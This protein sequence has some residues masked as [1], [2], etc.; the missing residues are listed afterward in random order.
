MPISH[1]TS[2]ELRCGLLIRR[3]TSNIHSPV[4]AKV[5]RPLRSDILRLAVPPT[6]AVGGQC[7]DATDHGAMMLWH[8]GSLLPT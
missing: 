1:K 4:R 2:L 5:A 7:S 3:Q 6:T 8:A